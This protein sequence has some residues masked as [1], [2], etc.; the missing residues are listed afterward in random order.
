MFKKVQEKVLQM[1]IVRTM[2]SRERGRRKRERRIKRKMTNM[3]R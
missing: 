1:K 3:T 2:K